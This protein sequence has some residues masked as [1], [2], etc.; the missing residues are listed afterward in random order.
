M[1]SPSPASF[2]PLD[3]D[4]DARLRRL[5]IIP[6]V[7]EPDDEFVNPS[8]SSVKMRAP[9]LPDHVLYG[10]AGEVVRRLA[11]HTEADPAAVYVQLL[12]GLGNMIGPAPHFVADGS[13]H[14]T[15]LFCVICGRTAKARKGTSWSAARR[16]LEAVDPTWFAERVHSGTVSGE[17]IAQVLEE[18]EDRRLLLME[19]EFAQVLQVMKREGNTVSV[20]LRQGWD[21]QRIAVLRRKDPVRVDGSHISLIGHITLPELHRLLASVEMSNGTANRCLWIHA[22]RS[23]LLP[24]GGKKVVLDDLVTDLRR[25]VQ[26]ARLRGE[27]VRDQLA[28]AEWE[29]IY[30]ALS[31]PPPGRL[32]EILSRGEAQVMRLALLFTLLD[33]ARDIGA[34]HLRAALALWRYCEGSAAFIFGHTFNDSKA[35]RIWAALADAPLRLS[36]VHGLFHR[37]ATKAEIDSALAELGPKILIEPAPEGGKARLVRRL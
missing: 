2:P 10:P 26:S 31:E 30:A 8:N 19:G 35:A 4:E 18:G 13:R 37:N 34:A 28:D 32:G 21:G 20:L 6:Y 22:E 24:L 33:Q 17:G 5:H 11:P 9:T 16:V 1:T 25:A 12:T 14:Q 15:N 27:L 7:P 3:S 29:K 23:K 36:E